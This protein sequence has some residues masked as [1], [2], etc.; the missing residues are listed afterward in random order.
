MANKICRNKK[1]KWLNDKIM[2]I[3]ENHKKNEKRKFFEGIETPDNKEL[4]HQY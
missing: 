2:R 1:K 3:E 4:I